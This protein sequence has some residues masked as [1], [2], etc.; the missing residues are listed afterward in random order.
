MKKLRVATLL[1]ALA[2]LSGVAYSE[3]VKLKMGAGTTDGVVGFT[4]TSQ[5]ESLEI[6]VALTPMSASAKAIAVSDAVTAQDASGT[7]SVEATGTTLTFKHLVDGV[8]EDVDGISDVQD[9]TGGGTQVKTSAE[10]LVFNLQMGAE[11]TATGVDAN[12]NPSF[13]TISLT[14]SLVWTHAIQTGDTP[15]TI[16]DLFGT[17]L[18]DQAEDAVEV[19]R[20]TP[21]VMI[22][23]QQGDEN[24]RAL[25]INWQVT[26]T[27]LLAGVHG[28]ANVGL[29][30][31]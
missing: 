26:D 28:S 11:T 15:Q 9:T 31:R 13:I 8:W 17:F 1:S 4:L 6:E 16:L 18:A 2:S 23:K 10:A 29:I 12:G 7:W 3:D 24:A 25:S 20:E 19:V 27:G 30:D 14:S 21:S 5:E 22:L